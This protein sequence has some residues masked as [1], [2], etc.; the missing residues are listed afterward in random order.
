[1]NKSP[2][3]LLAEIEYIQ[4]TIDAKELEVSLLESKLT[5]LNIEL[6]EITYESFNKSQ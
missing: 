5:K 4:E 6:A 3:K 2:Q 1:M